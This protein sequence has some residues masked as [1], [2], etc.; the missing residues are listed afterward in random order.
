MLQPLAPADV[1]PSVQHL[2]AD[3]RVTEYVHLL[4]DFSTPDGRLSFAQEMVDEAET[5]WRQDGYT[6]WTIRLREEYSKSHEFVGICGFWEPE[7]SIPERKPEL[8]YFISHQY[9]GKGMATEAA[10]CCLDWLFTATEHDRVYAIIDASGNPGTA[11]VIERLGM[12]FVKEV[13]AYGSVEAGLGL[14][15]LYAIDIEK[16]LA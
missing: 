12:K 1:N 10:R 7:S 16:Y 3:S 11:K 9:W 15:S 4:G 5:S 13:D 14:L 8:G 2:W 6:V